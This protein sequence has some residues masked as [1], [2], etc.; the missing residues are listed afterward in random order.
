MDANRALRAAVGFRV[1]PGPSAP[2]TVSMMPSAPTRRIRCPSTN[3]EPAR[4]QGSDIAEPRRSGRRGRAAIAAEP[5]APVPRDG[6]HPPRRRDPEHAAMIAV[7]HEVATAA[8]RRHGHRGERRRARRCALTRSAPP[9]LARDPAPAAVTGHREHAPVPPG[10][11]AA[12]AGAALSASQTTSPSPTP[13]QRARPR[14]RRP[15]ALWHAAPMTR[16]GT[17]HNMTRSACGV[18]EPMARPFPPRSA[19]AS[20]PPRSYHVT[21]PARP[22]HCSGMDRPVG[23][24]ACRPV[25]T[26]ARRRLSARR[27]MLFGTRSADNRSPPR[28]RSLTE[29]RPPCSGRDR[30]EPYRAGG[31]EQAAGTA[32][33]RAEITIT[34]RPPGVPATQPT[35]SVTASESLLRREVQQGLGRA[36]PAWRE[37]AGPSDTILA[38]RHGRRL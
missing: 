32:R 1:A 30:S 15:C 4:S 2:A 9:S 19:G 18:T 13:R 5:A 29:L 22:S 17:I 21:R 20:S 12:S 25:G 34:T 3:H 23:N 6:P 35:S 31:R 14:S 36:P 10:T 28:P 7:D 8:Q 16:C 37:T 38:K 11:T 27:T 24:R 26:T 33:S